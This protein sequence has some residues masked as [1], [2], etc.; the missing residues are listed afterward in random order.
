M[1]IFAIL[2]VLQFHWDNTVID[3]HLALNP[4]YIHLI[5]LVMYFPRLE[6]R[7]NMDVSSVSGG[8]FGGR[9]CRVQTS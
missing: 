5:P 4:N 3:C 8:G 9:F 2:S 1:N 7:K 6:D